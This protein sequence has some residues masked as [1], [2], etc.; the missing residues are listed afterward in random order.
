MI[1]FY[2]SITH[3]SG[4]KVLKNPLDAG[5]N[6]STLTEMTVFVKKKI[7]QFNGTV[8]EQ[9]SCVTI[10]NECTPSYECIFMNEFETIVIS[11]LR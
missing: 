4:L 9:I 10:S 6:K 3:D 7:V 5:K 8:K 1:G 11:T 2:L